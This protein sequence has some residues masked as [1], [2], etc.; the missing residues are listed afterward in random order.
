M[1]RRP[2]L[3][4]APADAAPPA[5]SPPPAA[6]VIARYPLPPNGAWPVVRFIAVVFLVSC[7]AVTV[8]R[9]AGQIWHPVGGL[10][11]LAGGVLLLS[12]GVKALWV[13]RTARVPMLSAVV[14]IVA[15]VCGLGTL[16]AGGGLGLLTNVALGVVLFAA[17]FLI[18]AA[19]WLDGLTKTLDAKTTAA[20]AGG[21]VLLGGVAV[22]PFDSA[23]FCLAGAITL[24]A[25]DGL[26]LGLVYTYAGYVLAN[27][28]HPRE[29]VDAA[30][31]MAVDDF[32]GRGRNWYTPVLQTGTVAVVAVV[33]IVAVYMGWFPPPADAPPPESAPAPRQLDEGDAASLGWHTVSAVV[34]VL[35]IGG[36]VWTLR[37]PIGGALAVWLLYPD[38]PL[39]GVFRPEGPLASV[40]LRRAALAA[41]VA[42]NATM[43]ST[44]LAPT[45]A[46]IA[47]LVLTRGPF[48]ADVP[49]VVRWQLAQLYFG[50]AFS[51]LTP[52]LL[53]AALLVGHATAVR[54]VHR[55]LEEGKPVDPNT[56]PEGS[57]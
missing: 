41:V 26:A 13:G 3:P 35:A 44:T 17:F 15:L 22:F 53:A 21:L 40:R 9:V 29:T 38:H 48:P 2:Y 55:W 56:T 54:R 34:L 8:A 18:P 57:P 11:A 37:R 4:P 5:D 45:G 7:G 27:P 23:D 12:A 46:G 14:A 43:V 50:Y 20:L 30:T 33:I 16:Q 52:F 47:G 28:A 32:L 6:P 39:P 1:Y 10:L 24:L 36:L 51:F 31:K 25:N 49:E 19:W 42:L